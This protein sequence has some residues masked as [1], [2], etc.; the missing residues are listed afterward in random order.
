VLVGVAVCGWFE[1]EDPRRF[2]WSNA[3]VIG[4]TLLLGYGLLTVQ[5]TRKAVV[6]RRHGKR[7]SST[8]FDSGRNRLL[9]RDP[10]WSRGRQVG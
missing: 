9:M 7:V 8:G 4:L 5:R 10:L 6:R 3:A 2:Y 1:C